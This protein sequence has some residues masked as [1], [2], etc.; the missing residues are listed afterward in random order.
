MVGD[1]PHRKGEKK[2]V[3]NIMPIAE[4]ETSLSKEE[5]DRFQYHVNRFR[6]GAMVQHTGLMPRSTI[7]HILNR[8][9]RISHAKMKVRGLWH[10]GRVKYTV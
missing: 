7:H 2:M 10:A 6:K 1:K 3:T 5:K 9:L 8:Y 4:V